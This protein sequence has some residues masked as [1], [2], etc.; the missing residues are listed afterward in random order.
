MVGLTQAWEAKTPCC[1]WKW[2]NFAKPRQ[3]L[4]ACPVFA[5]VCV[6][7]R[8]NWKREL[9]LCRGRLLRCAITSHEKLGRVTLHIIHAHGSPAYRKRAAGWVFLNGK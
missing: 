1:L 4:S 7:G 6:S 5:K 3:P 8:A 9:S 2:K